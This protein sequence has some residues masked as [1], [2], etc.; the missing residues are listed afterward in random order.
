MHYGLL[1]WPK[2]GLKL[3]RLNYRYVSYRHAVFH[4]IRCQLMD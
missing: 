2:F 3:K 4:F 1:F